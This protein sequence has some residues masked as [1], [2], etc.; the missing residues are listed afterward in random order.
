MMKE[1]PESRFKPEFS[2]KNQSACLNFWPTESGLNSLGLAKQRIVIMNTRN[3]EQ[4]N[5]NIDVNLRTPT[6]R[7]IESG[8]NTHVQ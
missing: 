5:P 8:N 1:T 6:F 2:N 3:S 4:K 7:G